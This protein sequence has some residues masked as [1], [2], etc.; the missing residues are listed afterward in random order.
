LIEIDDRLY[1]VKEDVNE[2]PNWRDVPPS[3]SVT[4]LQVDLYP[5]FRA[6]SL[7]NIITLF[8]AT[9]SEARI[10]FRSSHP[11]M[12]HSAARALVHLIWPFKFSGVFIPILPF[13]LLSCLEVF[14]LNT[15]AN[16]GTRKL[17]HRYRS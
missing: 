8:E 10:I 7:K 6:L 2:I 11:A 15:A 14:S 1:A 5:L 9:I 13:R 3:Y 12:L 4:N 17:Y 16:A